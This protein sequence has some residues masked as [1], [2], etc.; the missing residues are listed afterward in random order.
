MGIHEANKGK[1]GYT[2]GKQGKQGIHGINKGK[3][4]VNKGTHNKN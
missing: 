2:L 4:R 3:H 1:H